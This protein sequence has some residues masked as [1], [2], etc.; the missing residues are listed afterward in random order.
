MFDAFRESCDVYYY[1]VGLIIGMDIINQVATVRKAGWPARVE[2]DDIGR[3]AQRFEHLR[4]S[5]AGKIGRIAMAQHREI[6]V[7]RAEAVAVVIE[8]RISGRQIV[9]VK[10]D[11]EIRLD[12]TARE[13]AVPARID[14]RANAPVR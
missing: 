10:I 4:K 11:G 3:H 9:A 14:A 1:Q 7:D 6:E 13:A 5:A 8:P 12:K 2:D